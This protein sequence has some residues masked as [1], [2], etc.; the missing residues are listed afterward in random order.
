MA[1]LRAEGWIGLA[2]GVMPGQFRSDAPWAE[3]LQIARRLGA[4]ASGAAK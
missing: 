2:S 1:A 4:M 3:I